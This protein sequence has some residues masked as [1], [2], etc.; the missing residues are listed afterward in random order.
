MAK[1]WS[2][3]FINAFKQNALELS[4]I[5]DG[6]KI[7]STCFFGI[8]NQQLYFDICKYSVLNQSILEKFT[9]ILKKFKIINELND[10]TAENMPLEELQKRIF[11]TA[12]DFLDMSEKVRGLSIEEYNLKDNFYA[13]AYFSDGKNHR[14]VNFR[15]A[16]Y[17]D[18]QITVG[19]F[20]HPHIEFVEC[21]TD[22][23]LNLLFK[24]QSIIDLEYHYFEKNSLSAICAKDVESFG[25][26]KNDTV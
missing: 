10:A 20:N 17:G 16:K 1:T 8:R 13:R 3:F 25:G 15:N 23:V 24:A 14:S 5:K 11:R 12:K 21:D 2:L 7:S 6:T 4:A 22:M 9:N 18:S 19:F 26:L